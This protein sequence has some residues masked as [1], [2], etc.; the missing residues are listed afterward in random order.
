MEKTS[1]K[2]ALI[3]LSDLE[4]DLYAKGHTGVCGVDEVGR[5]PLAGPVVA[6]AVIL[7]MGIVIPGVNDSKKLS[8]AQRDEV[9]AEIVELGLPLAVGIIDHETIDKINILR[10]SLM[11]MR[12]AVM[13]LNPAPDVLLI[14]GSFGIPNLPQ[15]Q[16]AIVSGDAR[17]KSIGAASIIAKVTRDRIMDH[18]QT[19]YPD[20]SFA[21]HKGYPT[22]AH[23]AELEKC[24]PCAIHRKSFKPV[25]KYAQSYALF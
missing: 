17:C 14:D 2:S 11:A 10:A 7:P 6:A 12:K 18:Y 5:G 20:F 4:Q 15:A 13:E 8:A 24:G 16:F 23:L 25:A 21:E 3:D 22:P 9:F 19:L 1:R